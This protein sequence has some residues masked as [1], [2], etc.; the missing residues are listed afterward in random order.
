MTIAKSNRI[1][2]IDLLRGLVMIIMA[3]DHS[4]DFFHHDAFAHDPLDVNTTTVYLFFTRWITHFCAPVF[5]FLAGT[6][7]YLQSLRKTKKE[8]SVFLIKRGL[9]LMIL[10]VLLVNL[11]VTFDTNY[12]LIA[13]QTIWAIGTSMVILGLMINL[14][15]KMIFTIGLLIVLGHNSLDFIEGKHT[16]PFGFW[17]DLLHRGNFAVHNVYGN[18][19]LLMIY[20]F[21]PWSGLMMLG[22]CF[23]KIYQPSINFIQRRKTLLWIGSSIIIFF[24]VL[25]ASNIYGDPHQ[26]SVQRNALFTLLSFINAHKYPP[27]LLYMCMTIGPAIIFLASFEKIKNSLTQIII[28]YGKVPF[29]YYLLHFFI[30]HL[31]SAIAFIMRGHT[32][33][34]GMKGFLGLKFLMLNDGYGLGV[35]YFV[36][37]AV[38]V[39]LYPVCKW[40]SEY[41]LKHKEK[42]WLSYL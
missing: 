9:W 23:G 15:Y 12:E 28:V 40:F 3:L 25:R 13:L 1:E 22:Y 8:L 34:E 41:K 7:A 26:W 33:A 14:P 31:I 10:E 4:R 6:S 16:E 39:S 27:S 42:W 36:W 21:V 17:W 30:I 11:I 2:S 20:A 32:Y 5:V 29:L 19:S 18:H 24:I 37:I 35:V 38:V